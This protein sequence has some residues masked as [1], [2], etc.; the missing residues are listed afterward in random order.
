MTITSDVIHV[1]EESK[2]PVKV[3]HFTRLPNSL[4][5]PR[6]SWAT[7]SMTAQTLDVTFSWIGEIPSPAGGTGASVGA[8][9]E[10]RSDARE[11]GRGMRLM[12][13]SERPRKFVERGGRQCGNLS[14]TCIGKWRNDGA[15]EALSCFPAQWSR[16]DTAGRM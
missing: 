4:T 9:S 7:P 1:N 15:T 10:R 12:C 5:T 8:D 3:Q 16:D 13:D 6:R 14:A 2:I 11:E